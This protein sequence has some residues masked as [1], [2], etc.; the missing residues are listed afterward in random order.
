MGR[1]N[2]AIRLCRAIGSF[3]RNDRGR[4][5]GRS[6]RGGPSH[7]EHILKRYLTRRAVS[8]IV[9]DELAL[10]R[11]EAGRGDGAIGRGVDTERLELP[12][13]LKGE[14]AALGRRGD[15]AI[16]GQD[17]GAKKRAERAERVF[18]GEG[19]GL[20]RLAVGDLRL[21]E[22]GR[23]EAIVGEDVKARL[24]RDELDLRRVA[25]T[26]SDEEMLGVAEE[27]VEVVVFSRVD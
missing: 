8:I 23:E 13:E 18:V 19:D 27:E 15:Q 4:R 20:L 24:K 1:Q 11:G 7:H 9:V 14:R 12:H 6:A 10:M 25:P 26:I 21:W 16:L 17:M 3:V 2:G 5:H 22:L